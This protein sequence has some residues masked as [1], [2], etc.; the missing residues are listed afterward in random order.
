MICFLN[1]FEM[2]CSIV[3]QSLGSVKKASFVSFLRQIILFI[4]L[5]L[6]I[7]S[8]VGLMGALYAG[9]IADVI[10]F[11]LVTILFIFEY[12][13]IGKEKTTSYALVDDTNSDNILNTKVIITIS[14]EYGSG[15][16]YI[17]RLVADKLGIKFYDKD[18]IKIVSKEAG[19]TEDF[20][21]ENEQK[22]E[23]GSSLNSEYNSNDKL[24]IAETKVIK[25]IA[26]NQSCVIIG[27]CADYILKDNPN[28]IKIF[29]Y[30][31]Q[32]DKINRAVKYYNMDEKNAKK[33]IEK[34]NK[35]RARHY[36][37]YTNKEWADINNYDFA[38]NS[39]YLGVENT[40]ELIKDIVMKKI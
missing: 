1:A 32:K 5:S 17:G 28:V 39:D 9:P 14:R 37:Y 36:K 33:E 25:E 15:G 21:E 7:S 2:T 16:R 6:I 35:E 24:F 34:V 26:S 30:S 38:F 8:R 27:R 20:I 31:S 13:K 18:L 29:I 10:C 40:A 4:P 23:W 3:F 22:R 19:M 11:V 12:K